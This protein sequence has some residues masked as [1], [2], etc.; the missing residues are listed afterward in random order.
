MRA[1]DGTITV[2]PPLRL[3]SRR[4]RTYSLI[5]EQN[6]KISEKEAQDAFVKQ[7]KCT[8]TIT[9]LDASASETDSAPATP[10]PPYASEASSSNT[11]LDSL[12]AKVY[13]KVS[14]TVLQSTNSHLIL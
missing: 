11:S 13:E 7:Q 12:G 9:E 3:S 5:D 8:F 14:K 1:P 2:P 6:N 4:R 10:V